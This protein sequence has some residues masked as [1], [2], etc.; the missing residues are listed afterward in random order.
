MT[1]AKQTF[2]VVQSVFIVA[3]IKEDVKQSPLPPLPI[4]GLVKQCIEKRGSTCS[5]R[6][7]E[8]ARDDIEQGFVGI[9][10]RNKA[11]SQGSFIFDVY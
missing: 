6:P 10:V 4:R 3:W 2:V 7:E 9:R 8:Q 5:G 11:V 1:L